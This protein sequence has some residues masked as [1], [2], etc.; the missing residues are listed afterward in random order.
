M[1]GVIIPTAAL[2]GAMSTALA[3]DYPDNKIWAGY[4]ATGAT[5][6][7]VSAKWRQ[8]TVTCTDSNSRVSF[9][10]GLDGGKLRQD[11]TIAICTGP[12]PASSYKA[13]WEVY[14]GPGSPGEEPFTVAPGDMISASVDYKDGKVTMRVHDDTNGQD[15]SNVQPCATDC[16]RD[17]AEWIVERPGGGKYGLA[18]FGKVTFDSVDARE[19]HDKGGHGGD[20]PDFHAITLKANG[21]TLAHPGDLHDDGGK[22][23]FDVIWDHE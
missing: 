12:G 23:H 3:A 20:Q 6:K 14:S 8:P 5:F 16:V 2:L 18:N 22:H 1:V 21:V 15:L 13:W 7:H 17:K 4:E 11:G 9:W 19:D 10:V